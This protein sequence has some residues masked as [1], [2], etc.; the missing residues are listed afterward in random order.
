MYDSVITGKENDSKDW[1]C[2]I[3]MFL[4]SF[5]IWFVRGYA[6][7]LCIYLKT[8]IWL[9]LGQGLAFFDEDR[10]ATLPSSLL[11]CYSMRPSRSL[12]F[13]QL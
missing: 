5:N 4:T 8:A 12:V 3:S 2:I 1:N 13:L 7:F 9:F 11:D 10:S 6:C